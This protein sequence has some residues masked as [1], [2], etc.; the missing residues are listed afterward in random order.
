MTFPAPRS[1]MPP[2]G[3][4]ALFCAGLAPASIWLLSPGALARPMTTLMWFLVCAGI[5]ASIPGRRLR[6][7]AWVQ[8]LALPWTLSWI[9]T[10]AITGMGPSSA[11]MASATKGAFKE[12]LI[13]MKMALASPAFV[14]SALLTLAL[15]AWAF[16]ATRK[17]AAGTGGETQGNA[18]AIVFFCLLIPGSAAILNGSHLQEFATI[19]APEARASVTWF[20]HL[21]MAK[22]AFTD[23]LDRMA[24]GETGVN[25]QVRS[26]AAAT[27]QFPANPGLAV[28]MVGESLRADALLRPERGEWSRGLQRRLDAGLGVRLPDACSG[29]NSTFGSLPRLLTAVDVADAAGAAQNPTILAV[30]KAGGARTAYINNHE[31]WVTPETGHDFMDKTSSMQFNALDEVAVESL[32]DFVKRTG[33]GPKAAVLHL[34]GQHFHYQD[35]YPARMFPAEPGGMEEDALFALRYDRSAEYTARVLLQ[36]AALL[37]AQT[38]PSFLVFTSD[39]GENMPADKIGMRFHSGPSNSR[40]DSTVPVL[41]LWNRAFAQT[42]KT[43]LLDKLLGVKGLIAHRDVASAWLAL[44][45]KPGEVLPT[46][47]PKTWGARVPG[48]PAGPVSCDS[49]AR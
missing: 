4:V 14:A 29:S 43:K 27:R 47:V 38:E 22:E 40:Y 15:L 5:G 9:A 26:G 6:W 25:E 49:L 37:D 20:S 1:L 24:T 32:G 42:G 13:G 12:V 8:A 3:R 11:V 17:H 45:G 16:W 31:I 48:E 39:H 2:H 33:P 18:T 34:Y 7:S 28:L 44:A 46:A 36:A 41:V 30:A 23:T 35:R 19:V 10:V 21:G